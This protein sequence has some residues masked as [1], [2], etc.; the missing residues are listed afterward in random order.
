MSK[1]ENIREVCRACPHLAMAGKDYL[2]R[3]PNRM[4][5]DAFMEE[6]LARLERNEEAFSIVFIDLDRFKLVNDCYGH[7][8]GDLVL[9]TV[10]DLFSKS[11]YRKLD[12]VGRWGGDEFLIILPETKL[13]GALKT[14]ER[15]RNKLRKTPL[16][17]LDSGSKIRVTASFG[18]AEVS[19]FPDYKDPVNALILKVDQAMYRAKQ[20]GRDQVV[21]L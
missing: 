15:I 14:A 21:S 18:V 12:K 5:L 11:L 8:S 3:L 13:E 2:T 6:C 20:A 16:A 7:P 1:D 19:A 17:I 4:M 9:K 10:A